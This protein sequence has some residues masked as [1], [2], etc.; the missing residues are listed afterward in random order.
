MDF[1][2]Q[3]KSQPNEWRAT[4][5]HSPKKFRQ[6]QSKDKQMIFAYEHQG[7]IMTE[8]HVEEV[9]LE[10]IIVLSCKNFAVNAQEP[11]SVARG[12]ATHSP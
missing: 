4:G 12:W 10:C 6:A 9:S 2:T 8:S 5:S 11:S 1:E 7:I 3:F